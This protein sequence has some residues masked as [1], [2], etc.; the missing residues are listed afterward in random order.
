MKM[1]MAMARISAKKA[2]SACE[3]RLMRQPVAK[4]FFREEQGLNH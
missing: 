3:N 1:L 4:M 2:A